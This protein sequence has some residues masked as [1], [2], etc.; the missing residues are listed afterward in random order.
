MQGNGLLVHILVTE[1][2]VYRVTWRIRTVE[3]TL[4]TVL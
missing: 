2:S 4:K 1:V 3:L